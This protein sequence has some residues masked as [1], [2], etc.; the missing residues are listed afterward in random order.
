MSLALV[1]VVPSGV[2]TVTSTLADTWAGVVAVI[3]VAE[4]AVKVVAG[5]A[6]N[7]T[8]LAA[9]RSVPVM[10]T[11][12]PPLAGPRF[13]VTAVTVGVPT[14]AEMPGVIAII[15]APTTANIADPARNRRNGRRGERRLIMFLALQRSISHPAGS[16]MSN[17][18]TPEPWTTLAERSEGAAQI[19]QRAAVSGPHASVGRSRAIASHGRIGQS[20]AELVHPNG[21][22]RP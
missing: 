7:S 4:F 21:L 13:G 11:E 16:G 6:P 3:C 20:T 1:S 22:T 12:T 10:T 19:A 9:A 18:S 14:A 17:S 2:T 15:V 5:V 8:E